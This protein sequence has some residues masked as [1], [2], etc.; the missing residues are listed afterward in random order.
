MHLNNR[1][2][3]N[4]FI[5]KIITRYDST[6]AHRQARSQIMNTVGAAASGVDVYMH[7]HLCTYIMLYYTYTVYIYILR[8]HKR[9]NT[10]ITQCTRKVTKIVHLHFFSLKMRCLQP[11]YFNRGNMCRTFFIWLTSIFSFDI[12]KIP[13]GKH[14]ES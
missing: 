3:T 1:C 9:I 12:L 11:R 14:A 4:L 7:I 10:I 8:N 6:W 13:S 5:P 2:R